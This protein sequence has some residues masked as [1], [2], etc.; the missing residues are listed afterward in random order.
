MWSLSSLCSK[1]EFWCAFQWK[2]KKKSEKLIQAALNVGN[3]VT[4][5]ENITKGKP[6]HWTVVLIKVLEFCLIR[7]T[8]LQNK[9][10]LSIQ[11]VHMVTLSIFGK[12]VDLSR[13]ILCSRW[14]KS[15]CMNWQ[16]TIMFWEI[17]LF[18]SYIDLHQTYGFKVGIWH[19]ELWHSLFWFV[20]LYSL[21]WNW[22]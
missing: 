19:R 14:R 4:Q 5:C 10:L 18:S 2:K 15:W 6:E 1:P 13:S 9:Y 20:R 11:L 7:F 16:R 21:M 8:P 17:Q 22:I 3:F 12:E